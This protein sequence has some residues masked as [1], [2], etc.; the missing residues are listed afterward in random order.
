MPLAYLMTSFG[1][2]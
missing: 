2:S 1:I